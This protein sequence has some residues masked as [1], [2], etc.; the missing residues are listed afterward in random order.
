M[1]A[2]LMLVGVVAMLMAITQ[3]ASAD[4]L[5]TLQQYTDYLIKTYGGDATVKKALIEGTTKSGDDFTDT[6]PPTMTIQSVDACSVPWTGAACITWIGSSPGP[7]FEH[8]F[9]SNRQTVNG[10]AYE[11]QHDLLFHMNGR[12]IR[13]SRLFDC[14]NSCSALPP[15][16]EKAF[17]P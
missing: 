6:L 17:C 12:W 10:V 14:Q 16:V 7:A 9:C 8:R 11:V 1:K 5:A 13:S 2:K 3:T 15:D 4:D